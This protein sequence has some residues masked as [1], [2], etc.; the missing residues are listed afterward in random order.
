[1]H[2]GKAVEGEGRREGLYI[3]LAFI[4]SAS[5]RCLQQISSA[6]NQ[7]SILTHRDW[8]QNL[9]LYPTQLD[10]QF[11]FSGKEVSLGEVFGIRLSARLLSKE[12]QTCISTAT[13]SGELNFVTFLHIS[14]LFL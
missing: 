13:D 12:H 1:M 5:L 3:R 14:I 7:D 11:V 9:I 6:E 2:V 10:G 4:L 8:I